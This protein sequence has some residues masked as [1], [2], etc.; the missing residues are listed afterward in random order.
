M[1]LYL[2]ICA[3]QRPLDDQSQLRIR[4][5][6]EA[7][8]GILSACIAGRVELVASSMHV[9]ETRRNPHRNRRDFAIEVL[10]LAPEVVTVSDAV[11]LRAANFVRAGIANADALHLAAAVE[12]NADYFCTTDDKLLKKGQTSD[13]NGTLVVTPLELV[14]K[15]EREL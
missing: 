10:T 5:E 1:R 13:T 6:T 4:L 12:A 9:L 7:V 11:V 14:S 15:L 3:I 2:D 8:L